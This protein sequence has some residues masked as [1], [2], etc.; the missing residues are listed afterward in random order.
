LQD[1]FDEGLSV[2][3]L[4]SYCSAIGFFVEEVEGYK[5]ASHPMVADWLKGARRIRPPVRP[6][7]PRWN[8]ALVLNALMEAPYEPAHSADLEAW[9]RK[10]AF[11]IAIT[12]ASRCSE[13]QALDVRPELTVFRRE[14]VSMRTNPSFVPKVLKEQYLNKTIDLAAFF[15]DPRTRKDRAW[16][17]LCPVRALRYYMAKTLPVRG[18]C[19]QMFVSP[20]GKNK[21]KP[22]S[23]QRIARWLT[24]VITDAYT[25]FGKDPPVG[26]K[27]HSTRATAASMAA[28]KGVAIAD[29]C[30]AASWSS[31]YVFA[32]FYR[33]DMVGQ[34][35]FS[36][37]VLEAA[38]G[39]NRPDSA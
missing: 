25:H 1:R 5:V 36:T 8:L 34:S 3:T 9:T 13:L 16:H 23:K 17:S 21:G 35:S 24:Q 7:V 14:A 31:H 27:A 10:T 38:T 26:V 18:S 2:S 12:S 22:V 15:P 32:N 20:S 28:L 4:K 29:I 6:V 11:I 19:H 37:R 33:L 30:R 39:T